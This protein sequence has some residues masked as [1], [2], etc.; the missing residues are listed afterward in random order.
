V[1]KQKV[2]DYEMNYAIKMPQKPKVKK[3]KKVKVENQNTSQISN[4]VS[5]PEEKP[6]SKKVAVTNERDTAMSMAR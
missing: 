1:K 2:L 6:L 4:P 5:N 3:Q